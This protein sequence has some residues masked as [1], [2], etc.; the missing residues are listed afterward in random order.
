MSIDTGRLSKITGYEFNNVQLLQQALTH[1]SVG[2]C[3]Y[4]RLEFLGDSILNFVIA[5]EIFHR[6]PQLNEGDLS[7]LR[8]SLVKGDRLAKI[9]AHSQ[10]GDHVV[11]G[12]GE[13]KSGGHRRASI[14]ADTLEALFGAIYI[15][16][17]YEACRA[18]I[19]HLYAHALNELPAPDELKDPK[20]RLQEWLQ[21]R[22]QPLPVYTVDS[23][24]GQ[25]HAQ[26]FDVICEIATLNKRTR[27][28]G[29]S[30]RKAEQIAASAMLDLLTH[31]N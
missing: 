4:E 1:R 12:P 2:G 29:K 21:A 10:L 23:V 26:T 30:R 8:A 31:A 18:T 22:S 20:T 5:D 15:D 25:S 27:G 6:R 17:G 14:L 19:L 11:L 7:R 24:S 13:M 3:N 16:G 28:S 9:A